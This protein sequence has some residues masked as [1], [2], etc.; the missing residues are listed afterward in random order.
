MSQRCW[1]RRLRLASIAGPCL[2]LRSTLPQGSPW[3]VT[4]W[5]RPPASVHE[6]IH[7]NRVVH[8]SHSKIRSIHT[9]HGV[10]D[11]FLCH[12]HTKRFKDLLKPRRRRRRQRGQGSLWSVK[13]TTLLTL[14]KHFRFRVT[15]AAIISFFR[16]R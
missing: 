1:T 3:M 9:Y 15:A 12:S 6:L 5:T 16:F 11:R 7:N 8:H 14:Q 13:S 2:H 10:L 4:Q